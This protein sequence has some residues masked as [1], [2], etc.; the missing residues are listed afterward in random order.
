M[1]VCIVNRKTETHSKS[2]LY[3]QPT[4]IYKRLVKEN[5]AKALSLFLGWY[6]K[7][8]LVQGYD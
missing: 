4:A 1:G 5:A 7:V 3:T 6:F 2:L 8:V